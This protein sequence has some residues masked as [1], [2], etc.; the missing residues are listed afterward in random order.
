M[1]HSDKNPCCLFTN[2]VET[3]SIAHGRLS[4]AAGR[5]V[6]TQGLPRLL[7]LYDEFDAKATFFYTSDIVKSHPEVVKT[8]FARGHEIACHGLS[9][10]AQHAFDLLPL[11]DQIRHLRTSKNILEDLIG[12]EV[13][14]FRAP[15][16]RVNKNTARALAETG[17][18]IDSS[19]ASQ[20]FDMFLSHGT[21]QKVRWLF[22]PRKP[23][24]THPD[25]LLK[26]G[27]GPIVEV[28]VSAMVLPYVGTTLRIFPSATRLLR[29]LLIWESK[30]TD[31][32]INFLTHPN[33]VIDEPIDPNNKVEKRGSNPVSSF[34]ADYLRTR[35]KLKNLG[36]PAIPLLRR[37]LQ[38]LQKAGF[39]FCTVRKYVE[40]CQIADVQMAND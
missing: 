19:V 17:F 28:P 16:L 6:A 27:N 31:R 9:H 29:R 40:M 10:E 32:P 20:R 38:A 13:V 7:D 25:N 2:D 14:T 5:L 37:E 23:Y 36:S 33:E 30:S 21:K 1:N 34:L 8:A 26:K 35:L 4:D 15:A 18:R 11:E 12:E 3:T 22:A 39:V 24:R